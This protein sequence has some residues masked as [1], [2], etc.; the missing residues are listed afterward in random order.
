MLWFDLLKIS[1]TSTNWNGKS[2]SDKYEGSTFN[3]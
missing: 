3:S 1:D 2:Y